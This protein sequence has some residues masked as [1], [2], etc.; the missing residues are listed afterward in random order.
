MSTRVLLVGKGAPERGGIPV[1][2]ETLLGSRLADEFDLGFLNLA[3]TGER[4][5][6][7]LSSAN[8][9]RSLSDAASV[10]RRAAGA[11]V[12]HLHTAAA[13]GV[14]LLRAGI[15]AAA[16]RARRA[17]VIVHVHGGLLATWMSS[18]RRRRLAKG[19]L[20]RA[21]AVVTVSGDA[22]AALADV[23]APARLSRIENGVDVERFH[24]PSVPRSHPVPRVLYV[25]LLTPRKGLLDLFAASTALL[26]DG[27]AHELVLVGGLPDEGS[28]AEDEVR[29]AAPPHAQFL[30]TRSH[31]LMPEAYAAAD[32][33]CLPSWWEAM[34]LSVLEAMASA[35][36][37][38]ATDVGEV[39]RLVA[40]G[41]TGHVVAPRDPGALADALRVL[42]DDPTRR[43]QLGEAGR[44]RAVEAYSLERTVDAVA[45]CYRRVSR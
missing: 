5:G 10:W 2:L 39:R 17:R 40:E 45:A 28:A 44:R 1:F 9:V 21:D 37:V 34:P 43:A 13:P 12:V 27:C 38:V 31:D 30:G 25:G 33:F 3:T 29:G 32:V 6:G 19:A 11:D 7:R 20:A 42:L 18:P 26:E 36:P 15:L 4:Q 22:E 35:L 14:T 8:V 24:P 23:V 16:G 41:V